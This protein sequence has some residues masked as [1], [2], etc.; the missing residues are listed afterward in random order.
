MLDL[1]KKI[2][3]ENST[4]RQTEDMARKIKSELSQGES[5]AKADRLYVPELDEM[6]KKIK[7]LHSLHKVMIFQSRARARIIIEISGDVELTGPKVKEIANLLSE[8][9]SV[10]AS[11][12]S[13]EVN[14]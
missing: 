5:R 13:S 8:S 7:E 6:A 9:G 2:L 14:Q 3:R 1:F 10:V 11:D 4:V 12:K